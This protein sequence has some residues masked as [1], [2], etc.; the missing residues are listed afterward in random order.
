MPLAIVLDMAG[1]KQCQYQY[2][3]VPAR[4]LSRKRSTGRR[5]SSNVRKRDSPASYRTLGGGGG[6]VPAGGGGGSLGDCDLAGGGGG[7][8]GGGLGE[9]PPFFAAAVGHL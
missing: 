5:T 7:G 2:E 1:S 4:R 3:G 6:G 8:G 9:L